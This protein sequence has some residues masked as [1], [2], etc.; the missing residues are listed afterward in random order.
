VRPG[1]IVDILGEIDAD[2]L[3]LQEVL[4]VEGPSREADQAQ[5]IAEELGLDFAFGKNVNTGY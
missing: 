2:I 1:R 4:S 3:A 5:F